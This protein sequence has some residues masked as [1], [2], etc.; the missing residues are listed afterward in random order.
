[1]KPL[2]R[3]K[4]ALEEQVVTVSKKKVKKKKKPN[5]LKTISTGSTTLNLAASDKAFGGFGQ[6]SMA[7]IIG[8]SASGK[9]LIALTTLAEAAHNKK[10]G[11]Y[12][13]IHDDAESRLKMNIARMFGKKTKQR[14]QKPIFGK[15][16][17]I[18][19]FKRNVLGQLKEG[20]RFIYILDSFD[21]ISSEA[22]IKRLDDELKGKEKKGSYG[23]EKAKGLSETLRMIVDG[24]EQSASLL[25]IISQT[26][27][28]LEMFSFEKTTRSGG[29]ALKFYAT[30][31]M[32]CKLVGK[33]KKTVNGKQLIVGN[34]VKFVIKK[35][36]LTG[37]ERDVTI[38]IYVEYGIDDTTTMIDFLIDENT[39]KKPSGKKLIDTKGFTEQMQ[40]DELIHYIEENNMIDELRALV[41]IAWLEREDK[42]AI[43]RKAKYQ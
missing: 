13:L 3:K 21:A 42:V 41:E 20:K 12:L 26:R 28:N 23:T 10:M 43:K 18:E 4:K 11:D 7:N 39:W 33:I 22:E 6:G 25:I 34:K 2:R 37:K 9:T 38:P 29:A 27:Q 16:K 19:G 32:W 40:K 31:E 5:R 1:M 15:S 8:D 14:L 35:N 36:S 30:H 17:T 24:I